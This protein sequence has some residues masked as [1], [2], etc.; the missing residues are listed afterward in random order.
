MGSKL[1]VQKQSDKSYVQAIH[2]IG[3]IILYK[4][5]RASWTIIAPFTYWF[6]PQ[7]LQEISLLKT[8]NSFTNRV[9]KMR[10]RNF[11]KI[12][13]LPISE[14]KEENIYYGK[15]KLAMLDLLLNAK[16]ANGLIDDDG[17]KDEVN[18]I[19]FEVKESNCRFDSR[20]LTK[21]QF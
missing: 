8:I 17:I 15:K 2:K 16:L 13:D 4:F 7:R 3:K 5:T 18:T 12:E 1:D 21:Q 20:K 19:M 11:K 10:E 9:I 14:S 6:Y